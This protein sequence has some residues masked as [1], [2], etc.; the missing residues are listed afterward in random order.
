MLRWLSPF[1]LSF[2]EG[3]FCGRF[4]PR[5]KRSLLTLDLYFMGCSPHCKS[6][7]ETD[8]GNASTFSYLLRHNYKY[9]VPSWKGIHNIQHIWVQFIY[10]T[11][12]SQTAP[13]IKSFLTTSM[14]R[15]STSVLKVRPREEDGALFAMPQLENLFHANK[16]LFLTPKTAPRDVVKR[17]V[18]DVIF[19]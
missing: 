7:T 8:L 19:T 2:S 12:I 1:H 13:S 3:F 11:Y 17:H 9:P 4:G 5:P 15:P 16:Q 18:Q 14:L 6:D 10:L